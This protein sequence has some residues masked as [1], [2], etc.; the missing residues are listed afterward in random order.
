MLDRDLQ[1]RATSHQQLERQCQELMGSIGRQGGLPERL[2]RIERDFENKVVRRLS[3]F[4]TDLDKLRETIGGESLA[5][6]SHLERLE[7]HVADEVSARHRHHSSVES[8][9]SHH[10]SI[11]ERLGYL[12][13]AL[14]DSTDKHAQAL[15]ATHS[16]LEQLAQSHGSVREREA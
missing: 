16:K 7:R 13:K 9:L 12:E 11:Q 8:A 10:S 3:V 5:R 2:E 1:E 4:E 14:G 6:Q 15:E